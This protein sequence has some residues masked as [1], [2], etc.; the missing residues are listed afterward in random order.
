MRIQLLGGVRVTDTAGR[1]I[2]IGPGRHRLVLATLAL[3][4]GRTVTIERLFRAVWNGSP[5]R[6]ADKTLQSYVSLLRRAIEP[7][8]AT[9]TR[10]GAAYVLDV[11]RAVVDVC[12]FEDALDA[13]DVTAAVALWTGTPLAGLVAPGLESTVTG[14]VNRWLGAVERAVA[15]D[16]DTGRT[17]DVTARLLELTADH[18]YHE[19]LWALL[20]RAQYLAGRQADA[21][22]SFQRA[23]QHLVEGLGIEPG[24]ALRDLEAA[25]L[26]QDAALGAPLVT[27]TDRSGPSRE[28]AGSHRSIPRSVALLITDIEGSSGRW[29]RFPDAMADA[30]ARH[31]EQLLEVV[32][33]RNGSSV[34]HTGDGIIAA[35]PDAAD[36]VEA[37]LDMR[38]T[39]A[40]VD[41][42]S[43]DGLPI[44]YAV[45]VGDVI[46]RNGELYGW[47]L[48]VAARLNALGRGGQILLS[49]EA[50]ERVRERLPPDLRVTALGRFQLRDIAAPV[51][52]FQLDGPGPP[53]DFGP[54]RTSG[55]VYQV[56]APTTPLIGRDAEMEAL[57][58]TLRSNRLVSLIG[59]V[60]IGTSRL[61]TEL[62]TDDVVLS[63]FDHGA[64][65]FDLGEVDEATVLDVVATGLGVNRRPDQGATGSIVESLR[66][67]SL[68]LVLDHADRHPGP[69]GDLIGALLAGSG[70]I[71]VLVTG[72]RPLGM[73]GEAIH[74]LAPLSPEHA[75]ELFRDRAVAAGA[76]GRDPNVF[77]E[78]EVRRLG[79]QLDRVP[80]S[81][82]AAASGANLYTVAEL[83]DRYARPVEG[84]EAAT[85]GPTATAVRTSIESLPPDLRAM[86]V[87]ATVFA[88]HFDRAAFAAVCAP[89][90]TAAAADAALIELSNRSLVQIDGVDQPR[91]RLLRVVAGEAARLASD[92]EMSDANDR[93]RSF[94]LDLV[95]R[96]AADL[97]GPDEVAAHRRLGHHFDNIRRVFEL[98]L[99]SKDLDTAARITTELW[100]YAFMR[101]N[102][103]YFRWSDQLLDVFPGDDERRLGPVL[104]V[105]ALGA[106]FHDDLDATRRRA[107]RALQLERDL[108]LDFDLP[109]RL[110]LIN[111]AVYSGA[112]GPPAEIYLEQEQ[113]QRARPERYFLVNVETQNAVMATWLGQADVAVRRGVKAVQLAEESGN[114]SSLAFAVWG[115]GTALGPDDPLQAEALLARA[116][117]NA[118][119]VGNQWLTALGQ[120]SL[121][122]LR[123]RT[124]SPIEAAPLLVD[125]L[126]LL[127]RAGHRSHLWAA[128]RL[129][130]LVLGEL[131]VTH[132][133]VQLHHLVVT[134][135]LAM[136]ALP[137]DQAEV[138]AQRARILAER[139]EDWVARTELLAS[140]WTLPSTVDV[141][142]TELNRQLDLAAEG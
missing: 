61:A 86:V 36:A 75:A 126:E 11:D 33:R 109:A 55:R 85:V 35:F 141:V 1:P 89:G 20:M 133:A 104:G 93:F 63:R 103:E 76:A 136:P 80:L 13:D 57:R 113:Y 7:H 137:A 28:P 9:V 116:V 21:L 108:D 138:D 2:D 24:R 60:G 50:V 12:R 66:G 26:R 30:L 19:G 38:R 27:P 130:G 48:N 53:I 23:R 102:D 101:F 100:D 62:A 72:S 124:G 131:G 64:S 112:P 71:S 25:I 99:E 87:A 123:R 106:W 127:T 78:A 17:G 97:R 14:L 3:S 77:P 52:V 67:R 15:A 140:A 74:R 58:H 18:P 117:E 110:A 125:L 84:G 56:P 139:G 10:H 105:A 82:V 115:L 45:H 120:L 118:R 40:T 37:A 47:A 46:D 22:G 54:L 94:V 16:L 42:S 4:P 135:N 59:P 34:A 81:L 107:D 6:T 98:A 88:G 49:W 96:A 43:V 121:A 95:S 73:A 114:P 65:R 70:R 92:G 68:L 44:R 111:A 132:L 128:L 142:R 69:A 51:E 29:E 91:F 41:F 122:A 134:A 31:D 83:L 39:L 129:C 8:G 90:S 5:P 119:L 32:E 79:D